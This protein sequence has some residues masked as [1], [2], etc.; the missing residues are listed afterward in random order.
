MV[1]ISFHIWC[2][3]LEYEIYQKQIWWNEEIMACSS[4][5]LKYK[6]AF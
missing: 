2:W 3:V 6:K 1:L 4:S 5:T